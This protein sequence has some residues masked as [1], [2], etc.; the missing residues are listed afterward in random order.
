MKFTSVVWFVEQPD[1]NYVAVTGK[2]LKLSC[3]VKTAPGVIIKYQ[4]FKCQKN[5]MGKQPTD[6]YSNVMVL[7]AVITNQGHYLCSAMSAHSDNIHSE[8]AHV[9]V[10]NSADIIIKVSNQPPSDRYVELNEKLV[11]KFKATC[12]HFPVEY[13]WFHNFEKLLGCTNS[14][15]TINSIAVCHIG[16]YCC[17]ATSDYSDMTV[18]SETCRVHWSELVE[19]LV[20]YFWQD[21][22]SQVYI[23]TP[24]SGTDPEINQGGWLATLGFKLGPS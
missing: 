6:C 5:G 20:L 23:Y 8:V 7:P 3:R 11:I 2:E 1:K 12:K 22:C 4:W 14:T 13:Q 17:K 10:I 19:S 18:T 9:K 24:V 15:L 16:S 21:T